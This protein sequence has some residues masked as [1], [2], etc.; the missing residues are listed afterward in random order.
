[1]IAWNPETRTETAVLSGAM[2][3]VRNAAVSPDGSTLYTAGLGGELLAWD[4]T[5]TRSF[6]RNAHVGPGLPCCDP[7]DPPG[8]PLAVSPDGSLFAVP[9]AESTVGLFSAQTL[10]PVTSFKV[11]PAGRLITALAWSPTG[12]ALAVGSRGGDVQL[13]TV[14]VTPHRE[15]SLIGLAPLPGQA[16]SVQS[17]AFSPNGQL[18]AAADKNQMSAPGHAAVLSPFATLALWR[19]STGALIRPPTDL[20]EGNGLGGSDV[21]AFSRDGKLLA[22]TQLVGGIRIFDPSTGRRLRTLAEPR[23]ASISVAFAPNGSLAA[24]TLGGTV[25]MW[26]PR[27]GKRLAPPLLAD[28][29]PIT[30]VAFDRSG[31]RFVTTGYQDGT[32]KLWSSDGLQQQGPRLG[33]DPSATSTALFDPVGNDLLL[34]DDHGDAFTWPTSLTT[35]EHRACSLAGRFTSAAWAQLVGGPRYASVCR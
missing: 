12:T 30:S 2:G 35:W 13:W 17:L 28:S 3:H 7:V 15:Q 26:D 25:E 31:Q 20:G 24:G 18:L 5:G 14:G 9:I 19:V 22:A 34:V 23:S 27:T 29:E 6:G 1:M 16:E 11:T 8:P 10:Q 33:S 32:I 4:L 21:V